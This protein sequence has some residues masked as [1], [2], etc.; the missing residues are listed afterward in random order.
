VHFLEEIPNLMVPWTQA[1]TFP[2]LARKCK[3]LV[4]P[5]W[6]QIFTTSILDGSTCMIHI[7]TDFSRRIQICIEKHK[8]LTVALNMVKSVM[9]AEMRVG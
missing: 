9:V 1:G 8:I 7:W 2:N 6:F 5:W 4:E 3:I